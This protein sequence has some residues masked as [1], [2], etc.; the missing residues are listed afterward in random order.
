MSAADRGYSRS[1]AESKKQVEFASKQPPLTGDAAKYNSGA[2]KQANTQILKKVKDTLSL[3]GMVGTPKQL[4]LFVIVSTL[5]IIILILLFNKQALGGTT[6]AETTASILFVASFTFFIVFFCFS[7]LPSLQDWRLLFSSMFYTSFVLL[8]TLA[9]TL[10][11]TIVPKQTLDSYAYIFAPI[12][13]ILA[14]GVFYKG[15]ANDYT[16]NLNN[17]IQEQI[18]TMIILSCFLVVMVISYSADPGNFLHNTYNSNAII[19]L[20][21]TF[22]TFMYLFVRLII[23]S[24]TK[25]FEFQNPNTGKWGVFFNVLYII[26]L[27]TAI[28]GISVK[29]STDGFMDDKPVSSSVISLLLV[30]TI[31]WGTNFFV[32]R[33]GNASGSENTLLRKF[34][35]IFNNQLLIGIMMLL[36]AIWAIVSGVQ[37][38]NSTSTIIFMVMMAVVAFFIYKFYYTSLPFGNS[39]KAGFFTLII[40]IIL[41]IPCLL[42]D[43]AKLMIDQ[44]KKTSWTSLIVILVTSIIATAYLTLPLLFDHINLQGGNQLKNEPI[45]TDT[46]HEISTYDKMNGIND[47]DYKYEYDQ[48]DESGNKVKVTLPTKPGFKY[49]Y[50]LSFWVYLNAEPPNT[51]IS[52]ARDTSLLNYGNKPNIRYNANT[53]TFSVLVV[54]E[55]QQT[56]E[57]IVVYE[58]NDFP[59]QRWNNVVINYLGGTMDIFL[60]GELVKSEISVVPYMSLDKLVVG[61]EDGIHGKVCNIVY[62]KQPLTTSKM[63]YLYNMVKDSS[64]PTTYGGIKILPSM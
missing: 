59:L 11:F 15:L 20:T 17:T 57:E 26:F 42:F 49:Q 25:N 18:K 55:Y 52:Y 10:V 35:D 31:I 2:V 50:G 21:I 47:N 30:T 40:N 33:S 41:Y 12:T 51:N 1:L 38:T 6:A 32:S 64:P 60:N 3:S 8:F 54:S 36:L 14:I 43:F 28:I 34:D 48:M 53:N 45:N 29:S 16:L 39:Q 22:L 13:L 4:L 61:E 44:Y 9:L 37:K 63:Y 56:R 5:S 24:T 27:L 46:S 19:T 23:S 7:I 62:F 58:T